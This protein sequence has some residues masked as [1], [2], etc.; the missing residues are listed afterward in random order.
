MIEFFNVFRIVFVAM[1]VQIW[2]IYRDKF[3]GRN[4]FTSPIIQS[5]VYVVKVNP[6]TSNSKQI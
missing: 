6:K 3:E 5:S 2:F 4:R 1:Q